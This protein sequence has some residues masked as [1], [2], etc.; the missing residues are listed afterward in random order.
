MRRLSSF[1]PERTSGPFGA[2]G[3]RAGPSTLPPFVAHATI[4]ARC[5]AVSVR[6]ACPSYAGERPPGGHGGMT[7]A[8]T[9]API[10]DARDEICFAVWSGNGAIP[11]LW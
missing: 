1:S 5:C 9:A 2:A 3:L 8:W 7:R 6:A 10:S 4:V 11:P